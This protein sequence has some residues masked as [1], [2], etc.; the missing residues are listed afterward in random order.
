MQKIAFFT[1]EKKK[2]RKCPALRMRWMLVACVVY[3]LNSQYI[4][5]CYKSH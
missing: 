5:F 3:M 2:Y 4:Y 1:S